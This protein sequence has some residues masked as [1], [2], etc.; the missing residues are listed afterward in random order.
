M[1]GSEKS[2]ILTTLG[3]KQQVPLLVHLDNRVIMYESDRIVEYLE[4]NYG[5]K[6]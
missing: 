6:K 3:G 2:S 1:K 4:L 5:A